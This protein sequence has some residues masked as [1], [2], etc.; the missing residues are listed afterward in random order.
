M[1]WTPRRL[2]RLAL[3]L[4]GMALGC[5]QLE[6]DNPNAPVPAIAIGGPHAVVV[7]QTVTLTATTSHGVDTSYTFA[8]GDPSL[9]TVD[10]T[11]P[12]S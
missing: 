6:S 4:A 1:T 11:S 8:S 5:A 3:F 7:G 2:A 9:A 10:V 12:A